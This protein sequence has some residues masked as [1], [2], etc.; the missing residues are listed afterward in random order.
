M[1]E[2]RLVSLEGWGE[3]LRPVELEGA[4]KY[5][6]LDGLLAEES[7]GGGVRRSGAMLAIEATR[8][9]R[10]FPCKFPSV[11]RM[12]DCELG[13][14]NCERNGEG[15]LT[16]RTLSPLLA[17]SPAFASLGDHPPARCFRCRA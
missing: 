12:E 16:T 1:D 7:A 5:G 3:S 17:L 2:P 15:A 9:E 11:L 13:D 8:C 6:L 14:S 10:R 4:G